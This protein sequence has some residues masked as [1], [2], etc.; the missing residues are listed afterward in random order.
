MGGV[1]YMGIIAGGGIGPGAYYP[2]L[3]LQAWIFLPVIVILINHLSSA[4]SFVLFLAVCISLE[5]ISSIIDVRP[6][7]Y[8][9][10]FY[11]YLFLLYLGCF[12]RKHNTQ[13]SPKIVILAA[14]SAVFLLVCTYTDLDLRPFF[15]NQWKG[16]NWLGYFYTIFFFLLLRKIY[17]KFNDSPF[18]SWIT[19]LGPMS[20][21][22]FLCQMFV[23]SFI[24]LGRF[25][26][27]PNPVGQYCAFVITTAFLSI[28]PIV[29][30]K[31]K[32]P[33]LQRLFNFQV[34]KKKSE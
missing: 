19:S 6:W 20:Y 32:K 26:F 13:L 12:I 14:I 3:Y 31:R 29:T 25:A 4:K 11:R 17:A 28:A 27:I 9:L 30:Y 10:A 33:S 22:I 18:V 2:W 34:K 1:D 15:F 8:R 23:F 7:L 21:E 16:H 24:S 5:L